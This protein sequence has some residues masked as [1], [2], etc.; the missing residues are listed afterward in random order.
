MA[1]SGEGMSPA[2]DDAVV[3]AGSEARERGEGVRCGLS[4]VMG[5]WLLLGVEALT[6]PMHLLP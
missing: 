3:V 2:P 6:V 5:K 4:G 1:L